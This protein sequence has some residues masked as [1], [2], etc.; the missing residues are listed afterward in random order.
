MRRRGVVLVVVLVITALAVMVA[1]SLLFRMTAEVAASAASSRGEQAYSSAM[2]GLQQAIAALQGHAGESEVWYDNPELFR[3]QFVCSDGAN[4]WYFTI[5]AYNP[6]DPDN[7]RYGV[8]DEA[9][10][11]NVNAASGDVLLALPNMTDEL[12]DGLLDYVDRDSETRAGGGE[13]DYYDRLKYPYVIKNGPLATLEELLLV[14]GFG[15]AAVYGEDANLNGLREANEDDADE[16]FPPD[17]RDG[18]LNTGMRNVATVVS[19]QPP[20][21]EADQAKIDINGSNADLSETGLP[22]QTIQFIQLYRAEGR[23]FRHPSELLEMRYRLT[24]NPRNVQD[25]KAGDWIES[26]VGAD[27]LPIVMEKL[28]AGRPPR[29]PA[30]GLINVNVAGETVLSALPGM[31]A[32]SARSIVD[33]R[34][35]LDAETK[36]NLAWLYTQDAVDADT[37][38]AVAPLLT[39]RGYQFHVQCVGFGNPIGRYCVLEAIV[40]VAGSAPRIVYLRD[41]TRLGLPLALRPEELEL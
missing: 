9:G 38:K 34:G 2:S 22:D 12:V 16:S 39:T 13:Q 7:V 25:L 20:P 27:E 5:Y 36:T 8:T 40:D 37:F 23:Q 1:A 6:F 3:N 21:G 28:T 32:A 33:R 18:E 26:G 35:D 19:Y 24:R 30:I 14:K 4:R 41:I 17:N 29:G 15:A 10:K 11:I 31:D